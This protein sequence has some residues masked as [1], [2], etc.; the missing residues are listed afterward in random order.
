MANILIITASWGNGHNT[1]AKGLRDEYQGNENNIRIV[2][3]QKSF[4][5]GILSFWFR[6]LY[7]YPFLWKKVYNDSNRTSP[8]GITKFFLTHAFSSYIRSET[9][10][11]DTHEIWITNPLAILSTGKVFD[12]NIPKNVIITD[13]YEPHFSWCWGKYWKIYTPDKKAAEFLQKKFPEKYIRFRPFPLEQKFFNALNVSGEKK[14]EWKEDFGIKERHLSRKVI[15]FFFHHILF[16]NEH[17]VID[18]YWNDHDTFII[19]AGKN[20]E[21]FRYEGKENV[22]VC[23]WRNDMEKIYAI[24]ELVIGKAGGAFIAESLRTKTPFFSYAALPGQEEGNMK[25]CQEIE[26]YKDEKFLEKRK[27]EK[28]KEYEYSEIHKPRRAG[29]IILPVEK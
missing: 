15:T 16:G 18:A 28:N 4:W 7:A 23:E 19:L 3:I 26:H 2:D 6:F 24:S 22:V 8:T 12:K 1:A 27:A 10:E 21:E 14:K 9:K 11:F 5:G 29:K 25:M 20:A 13:F 17:E